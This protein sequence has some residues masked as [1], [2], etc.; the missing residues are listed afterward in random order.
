VEF[1]TSP[2]A[3][4]MPVREIVAVFREFGVPVMV[5]AAHGLGAVAPERL[6]TGCEDADFWVVSGHKWFCNNRGCAAL[7]VREE[8]WKKVVRPVVDSWGAEYGFHGAFLWQGT[9][10]YS[11]LITMFHTAGL[12]ERWGVGRV[13]ERNTALAREA[14]EYLVRL[15]GTGTL[16]PA[17]VTT[18]M[19]CVRLPEFDYGKA[20]ESIAASLHDYLR[21]E[22]EIE[23]PV[24]T[25]TDGQYV[26]ISVHVYNTMADIE[27]LGEAIV[28]MV[29]GDLKRRSISDGAV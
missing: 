15:W 17:E 28:S 7:V 10:D 16:V 25:F 12:W 26:R 21:D 2:T 3:V 29:S 6:L 20:V 14:V 4:V 11:P 8:R 18:C 23:V 1:L 24:F 9:G 19:V 22:L 27:R 5:D 13:V